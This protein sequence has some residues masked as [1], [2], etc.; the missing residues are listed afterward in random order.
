M[1]L[2]S[3]AWRIERGEGDIAGPLAE[4][5][6]EYPALMIGSYPFQ[7]NGIYGANIV[8][9]GHD[10]AQIEAALTRLMAQFPA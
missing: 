2:L 5:A 4:L 3:A 10:A 8:I 7:Q 6:Q 9:R 1:P